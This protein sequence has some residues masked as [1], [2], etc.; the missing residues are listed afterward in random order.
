MQKTHT[1]SL[2]ATELDVCTQFNCSNIRILKLNEKLL[3][4]AVASAMTATTT[5]S[6][7]ATATATAAA[8]ALTLQI[9]FKIC[10]Y[11]AQHRAQVCA[12]HRN[13]R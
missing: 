7:A 9:R 1:R 2:L 8:M 4:N 6:L 11:A 13:E 10:V 3:S 5:S 12:E